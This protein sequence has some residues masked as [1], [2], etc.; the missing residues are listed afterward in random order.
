MCDKG[1]SWFDLVSAEL[2]RGTDCERL[3]LLEQRKGRS[4]FNPTKKVRDMIMTWARNRSLV[5]CVAHHSVWSEMNTVN[6]CRAQN[7]HCFQSLLCHDHSDNRT[8]HPS[9]C[10]IKAVPGW[11]KVVEFDLHIMCT[12]A[13]GQYGVCCGFHAVQAG[14]CRRYVSAHDTSNLVHLCKN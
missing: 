4:T 11:F 1:R 5:L 7:P 14:R 10:L 9:C 2:C 13:G 8:E 3:L 6:A 12:G